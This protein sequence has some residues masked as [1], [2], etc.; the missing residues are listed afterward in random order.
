MILRCF[1][2]QFRFIGTDACLVTGRYTLKRE[3][4]EPTGMFTLLWRKKENE[5]VIVYDHTS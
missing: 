1:Q 4:D 3:K 2:Y 5:W